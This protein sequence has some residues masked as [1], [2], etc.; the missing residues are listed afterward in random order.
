MKGADPQ[1]SASRR[2][3]GVRWVLGLLLL[4]PGAVAAGADR[5]PSGAG[6]ALGKCESSAGTLLARGAKAKSWKALK[7]GDPVHAGDRLV[8]LPGTRAKV[9]LKGGITLDLVG[10]LGEY[11]ASPARESAVRVGRASDG[12]LG[13]TLERGRAVVANARDKGAATLAVGFLTETWVVTLDEPG[14]R[15]LLERRNFWP[16][17]AQLAK[18]AGAERAPFTHVFLL[19]QKGEG[20]LASGAERFA[21]QPLS[22]YQWTSVGGDVGP[23]PLKEPPA[24]IARRKEPGP[25]AEAKAAAA[26][27]LGKL[28]AKEVPAEALAKG[29]QSKSAALRRAAVHAAAALDDLGLLLKALGDTQHAGVR[30]TAVVALRH[31]LNQSADHPPQLYDVLVAGNYK[32][33]Q[34][35][36]VLHLLHSFSAQDRGRPETYELLIELLRHRDLRIRELAAWQLYRMVPQGKKIAYNA[37]GTAE[38]LDAARAA[39]RRLIPEGKLPPR[40]K[41]QP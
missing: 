28:L 3:A 11:Y 23:L 40:E 19:L 36:T 15:A 21:L 22:L 12:S 29:L 39:W 5:A 2:R 25:G 41:Q 35:E 26:L 31:W 37:A 1:A 33:A 32:P 18:K 20:H 14:T 38:E 7:A 24:F 10:L 30:D 27:R 34:A 17:G 13:L 9:R 6:A 8:A 4:Y 16:P